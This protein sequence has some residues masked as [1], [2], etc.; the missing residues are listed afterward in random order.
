MTKFVR[1]KGQL[2]RLTK[3]ERRQ[4]GD[5]RLMEHKAP[6]IAGVIYGVLFTTACLVVIHVVSCIFTAPPAP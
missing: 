5:R 6:F 3:Y 2:V 4:G 1:V